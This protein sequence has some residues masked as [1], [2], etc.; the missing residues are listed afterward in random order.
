[1]INL[2]HGTFT[3]CQAQVVFEKGCYKLTSSNELH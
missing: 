3:F 1:M 2:L